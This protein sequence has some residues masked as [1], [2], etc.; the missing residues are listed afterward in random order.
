MKLLIPLFFAFFA[1]NVIIAQDN[2]PTFKFS[3]FVKTDIIYDN[4]QSENLRE[5]HFLLYPLNEALDRNGVD[6][7]A[8]GSF[9]MLSI[10]TRFQMKANGPEVLEA[11]SSGYFEAEFFGSTDANINSFRLRHAWIKL[12]WEN[13]SLLAGQY[14][15]P[16][17]I[18]D[19]YPGTV[20]FNTGAPFQ[21]FSRNP[22]IRATQKFDAISISGIIN[23]Q[24][25]FQSPGPEGYQ[26]KYMRNAIVPSLTFNAQLNTEVFLIGGGINYKTLR[27]RLSSPKGFESK[28]TINSIAAYGYIKIDVKP[29]TF[30]SQFIYGQ[31][32]ADLLMLGSYASSSI[33]TTTGIETYSNISSMTIW[34]DLSFGS[35]TEIGLFTAFSGNLGA[36]ENIIQNPYG[37]GANIKSLF[38]ISPRI[39]QN[40]GKFR[41]ALE[42]EITTAE[43]GKINFGNKAEIIESHSFT[44][45]RGLLG[46]YMFFN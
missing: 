33:D 35:E 20:S 27:P 18:T 45:I 9:N 2:E 15:H 1:F 21:P 26:T 8:T 22:Q 4:R 6:T 34:G 11:K 41:I 42:T 43:Y 3:G 28:E 31:N 36:D 25:D 14:W 12:D 19:C 17:F 23:T 24:R 5:G 40:I 32:M 16:M 37:R 38:R 10:Q 29:F 44:N 46:I 30:K 7:N 13:T 39:V